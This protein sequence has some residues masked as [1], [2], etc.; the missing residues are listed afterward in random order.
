MRRAKLGAPSDDQLSC[1]K[2]KELQEEKK[3]RREVTK[4]EVTK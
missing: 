2:Y 4:Q 1:L 3:R